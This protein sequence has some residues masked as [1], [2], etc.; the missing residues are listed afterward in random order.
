M[1]RRMPKLVALTLVFLMAVPVA[2]FAAPGGNGKGGGNANGGGAQA[3]THGSQQEKEKDG[4]TA[5][6]TPAACPEDPTTPAPTE[7]APTEPAPTEPATDTTTNTE[8]TPEPSTGTEETSTCDSAPVEDGSGKGQAV[9]AAAHAKVGARLQA[10]LDAGKIKNEN[11]RANVQAVIEKMLGEAKA[12]GEA[13]TDEEAL[14]NIEAAIEAEAETASAAELDVLAEVQTRQGKKAEARETLK[15]RL[16][17]NPR[18]KSAYEALLTLEAEAGEKQDLDTFV[19]GKKV[20]FDVRPTVKDGRTLSPIRALVESIG[21]E[22]K[23]DPQ[24]RKVT[25]TK[26]ETTIELTIGSNVALVNGE[27]VELEVPAQIIDD[28]TMIPARVV[29]E[30]LGYYV[31]WL[32]EHRSILITDQPVEEQ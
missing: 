2:A 13:A 23:W 21:A 7:P 26:G 20:N 5:A 31:S 16:Q 25:I 10:A 30:K 12:E 24:T 17:K 18:T 32:A 3:G 19:N 9:S 22:V 6:E 11:A 28:R 29:V 8:T 15:A 1:T 27:Q 14:A 4:A